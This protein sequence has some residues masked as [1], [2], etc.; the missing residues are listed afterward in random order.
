MDDW[1]LITD[2]CFV[3]GAGFG[4]EGRAGDPEQCRMG[5]LTSHIRLRIAKP[6]RWPSPAVIPGGR[7][8]SG[9]VSNCGLGWELKVDDS[10]IIIGHWHRGR[11]AVIFGRYAGRI[12]RISRIGPIGLILTTRFSSASRV[13]SQENHYSHHFPPPMAIPSRPAPT[14]PAA[15]NHASANLRLTSLPQPVIILFQNKT[16]RL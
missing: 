14:P 16:F 3:R 10:E 7:P 5:G 12:G 4:V 15:S 2:D 1:Q 11:V 9:A 13:S 6:W 8:A